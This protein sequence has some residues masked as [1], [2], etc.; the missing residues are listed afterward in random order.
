[1]DNYTKIYSGKVRSIYQNKKNEDILL[2]KATNRLSSYDRNICNIPN[3]GNVLNQISIWWMNQTKHICPNHFI[4]Q[5]SYDSMEVKKCIPFKIEFVV[6]GYMTG[7]TNTSIWVN[8]KN[9]CRYF[10]GNKLR[11]GY[12]KNE[13]L[14]EIIITPTT[15]DKNDRPISPEEIISSGI[16]SKEEWETCKKYSLSLFKFGQTI[17]KKKNLILVDT[18]YEFGKDKNGTILL[19]DE[20]HTPDSSRYWLAPTYTDRFKN[21]LEPENIDKDIIRKWVIKHYDPYNLN[22]IIKV[23]LELI[24]TTSKKYTELLK[25]IT[26]P[27]Q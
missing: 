15:K 12:C 14:D 25:K 7:T 11:E 8:Y 13:K 4:K 6:R 27:Y 1:M 18:K 26:E 20:I 22:Q 10:C 17:M 5:V 24:E 16:M 9:G 21:N 19:I 23:P 2:M 3:K